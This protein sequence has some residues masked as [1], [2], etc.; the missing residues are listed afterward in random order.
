MRSY[1]KLTH[2]VATVIHCKT[3]KVVMHLNISGSCCTNGL[4][5]TIILHSA[6]RCVGE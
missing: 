3:N 2:K 5:D 6:N 1:T 4:G